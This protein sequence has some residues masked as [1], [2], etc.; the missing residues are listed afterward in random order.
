MYSKSP[1]CACG[2]VK[3]T[4]HFLFECQRYDEIRHAMITD[5]SNFCAPT[6]TYLLFKD[7]SV[8]VSIDSLIFYAVQK[9][10]NYELTP[11]G[12]TTSVQR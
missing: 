2:A 6:A 4:K 3:D 11:S 9:F 8:S 12:H 7:A 5:V 10:I 1:L